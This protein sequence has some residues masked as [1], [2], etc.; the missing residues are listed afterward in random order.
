M[1]VTVVKLIAAILSAKLAYV[2]LPIHISGISIMA[3]VIFVITS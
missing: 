1:N 3:T 2:T